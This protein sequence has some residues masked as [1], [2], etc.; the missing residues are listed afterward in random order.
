MKARFEKSFYRFLNFEIDNL[1]NYTSIVRHSKFI[2]WEDFNKLILEFQPKNAGL[3][4][5]HSILWIKTEFYLQITGM[6]GFELDE[7]KVNSYIKLWFE[8]RYGLK[9][10]SDHIL[11]F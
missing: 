3:G 9:I 7:K 1:N 2:K 6:F 8:K 4:W 11:R 5:G 10:H